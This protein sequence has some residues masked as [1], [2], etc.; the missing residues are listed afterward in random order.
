MILE[1]IHELMRYETAGDPVTGL[2]WTRK[3]TKKL[4]VELAQYRIHISPNT[5]GRLLKALDYRLRVNYK[6][7]ESGNRKPV[8]P[9]RRDEQF[10]YIKS[11]RIEFGRRGH[12]V[13]SVDSKKKELIGNFK[14]AGRSWQREP[15]RVNDHDFH[16]DAEGRAIPYGIYDEQQNR[17]YVVIGTSYETP[18]FAVD[19]I[20]EWWCKIGR[21]SYPNAQ[22][23]LILADCGGANGYRS[24]A[25]KYRL[26][27]ELCE[28]Y[29]L[30]VTVCHYPPGASK[31][32]PVEHRLFS[33]I[34][35]NW[36][37]RPLTSYETVLKYIRTTRTEAGLTVDAHLVNMIY[38]KGES[39]STAQ[40]A[41][42]PL[43]KNEQLP[44]W[45]Y[46]IQS[47]RM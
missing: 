35:K 44:D 40:M 16:I 36:A 8:D 43:A 33:E 25:W 19:S 45:N 29:E 2:K 5:V 11:R 18:A 1:R 17:G 41:T 34:S 10:R 15:I 9:L 27:R 24:R 14:N 3:T 20:V 47:S 22:E 37:G 13:I 4:A 21:K 46:T 38:E 26:Y 31:W 42:I 7:N 32:N 28:P 6:A 30:S 12:P 23:L 39:V